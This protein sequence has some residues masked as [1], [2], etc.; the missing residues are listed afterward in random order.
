MA[1]SVEW[2]AAM[3]PGQRRRRDPGSEGAVAERCKAS[4][5]PKVEHPPLYVKR[6]FGYSKVRYRGLAKNTQR[7]AL[8]LGFANL[9]IGD[10]RQ[11]ASWGEPAGLHRAFDARHRR[12]RA[13][14]CPMGAPTQP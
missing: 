5:R 2:P 8:L 13:I 10:G 6:S 9:L 1:R 14:A 4:V 12:E 3:L 11:G 7:L